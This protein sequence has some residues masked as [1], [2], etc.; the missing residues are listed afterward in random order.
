[1]KFSHALM[2]V[3]AAAAIVSAVAAC[4][5]TGPYYDPGQ[6]ALDQRYGA[7]SA[8]PAPRYSHWSTNM[9]ER[10]AERK[11]IEQDQPFSTVVPTRY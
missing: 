9:H 4:S 11:A 6:R 2:R 8:A 10:E 1:M 3:C 5:S 7:T